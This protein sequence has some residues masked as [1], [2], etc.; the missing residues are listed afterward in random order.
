M[1]MSYNA[2]DQ[3]STVLI[4]PDFTDIANPDSWRSWLV[5]QNP[6]ASAAN[7]TLYI[8]S[9]AGELLHRGNQTIPAHGINA[10][11]PRNLAD[12]D[13]SDSVVVASDQPIMG[14]CL[15]TRNSN[16]M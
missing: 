15:I 11:Q 2:L 7:I 4:Y 1:C 13:C 12:A 10:I 9:R 8:R 3:G 5:L 6:T 16:L 14:T